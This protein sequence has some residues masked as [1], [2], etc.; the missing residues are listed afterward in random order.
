MLI[1]DALEIPSLR[2]A[3]ACAVFTAV[4]VVSCPRWPFDLFDPE[5]NEE[6]LADVKVV[7]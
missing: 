4:A 1:T 7:P 3:T 2:A 6:C 5:S